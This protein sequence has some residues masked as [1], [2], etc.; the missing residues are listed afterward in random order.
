MFG[1]TQRGQLVDRLAE[2]NRLRLENDS[3]REALKAADEFITNGVELG[4]IQLPDSPD[5][6]LLTPGIVKAALQEKEL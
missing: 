3:L 6:A 5:P 1:I 4:Y 2:N